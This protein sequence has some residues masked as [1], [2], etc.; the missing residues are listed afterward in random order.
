MILTQLNYLAVAVSA[1]AYFSLGAIYFNPKVVGTAWMEE[2]KLTQPTE[3]QK[4]AMGKM[5]AMTL[6][7]CF[8]SCIGLNCIV[9][10]VMPGTLLVGAKIGLLA[11]VFATISI[12][13]SYLYTGKSFKIIV[14][15]T[16]YHVIGLV[17]A[18]VIQAAWL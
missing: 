4:K 8:V 15:D 17:L 2:H 5:M 16:A 10:I 11:S 7:M 18:G 3:E 13:M 6:V 12:A 14:I 9:M 1:L